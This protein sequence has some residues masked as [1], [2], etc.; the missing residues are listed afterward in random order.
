[1]KTAVASALALLL[2]GLAS[3]ALA[4]GYLSIGLGNDAEFEGDLEG[5]GGE[6]LS[7]GRLAI[8][9]RTG[10]FAIEASLLGTGFESVTSIGP[11]ADYSTISLGVGGK[12]Y[13]SLSGPIEGYGH[14]GLNKTWLSGDADTQIE[15]NGVSLGA[16]IQYSFRF[17]PLG[18]AAVW[19]DYT[20]QSM[21]LAD[22]GYVVSEL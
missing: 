9:Q 1:M 11:G 7:H 21:N 16:G 20:R 2:L 8:G 14:L 17:G 22:A 12:Y 15:G 19:L 6:G 13:I 4:G 3:P 18:D 5:R 10:P